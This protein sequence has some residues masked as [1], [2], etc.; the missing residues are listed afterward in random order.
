MAPTLTAPAWYLTVAPVL[1]QEAPATPEF[2]GGPVGTLLAALVVIALILFIGRYV[3]SVAWRIV[4]IA[5][6][7]VG[8]A[9]LV[10]NVLP[11]L[12]F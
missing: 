7:L 8:I 2:L 3:M 6:V 5:I 1:L 4:K 12:G 9:W 11:A 10:L